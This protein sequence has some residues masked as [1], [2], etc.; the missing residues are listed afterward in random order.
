MKFH[1]NKPRLLPSGKRV[2]NYGYRVVLESTYEDQALRS[3][4]PTF[5]RAGTG[6]GNKA[7]TEAWLHQIRKVV[8]HR[9]HLLAMGQP[10]GD[11]ASIDTRISEYI[12]W[13]KVQGGKKGLKW[14]KGHAEHISQYLAAWVKVLNLSSLSD[15]RQ[16]AFDREIVKL[17]KSFAPNTV[18]H[19]AR[20]LTALCS[21]AVRQGYLPSL[22]I[23]FRALDKTPVKERGAFSLDELKALFAG[24]PHARSLLYR[25]AYYLRLR[26]AELDSLKV[27]SVLWGDGFIRLDYKDAKDRK[28]ALIPVPQK[29]LADLWAASEGKSDNAPLFDFSKRHAARLLHKDMARLGIPLEMS[30][31]RRDFHSLGASTA[32]SMD[33]RGIAPA[34]ASKTMRHKSWAQT[35]NYIKLE[36]EQVRVV[37]Q[38]LEDEIEQP[39]DTL[40]DDMQNRSIVPM[41]SKAFRSD[42]SPSAIKINAPTKTAKFH[43]FHRDDRKDPVVTWGKFQEIVATL[44]HTI[45]ID[46][47]STIEAFLALSPK[48]R[49]EALKTVSK[50]AAV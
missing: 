8:E 35:E 9:A 42:P 5:K 6:R 44:R 1:L 36:T 34:L 17:S 4:Y 32:T 13:G 43:K 38:G 11:T 24:V 26:R 27:S 39:H 7:E 23:R 18:N 10:V 31:R 25:S 12:D 50:K 47:V 29:L 49:A 33:R 19:R 22:P 37:S 15:T 48:Q 30:G 46:G 16:G 28:T 2:E 21:W 20:A 40:G 3:L 45:Q 41:V 14:A